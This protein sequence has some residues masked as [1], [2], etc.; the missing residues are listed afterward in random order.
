MV[1]TVTV[2][3][4]NAFSIVFLVVSSI[5]VGFRR[6]FYRFFDWMIPYIHPKKY[7][8]QIVCPI[9]ITKKMRRV[10]LKIR[11]GRDVIIKKNISK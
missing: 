4:R 5:Q 8:G 11:N 6:F 10:S 2:T 1:R 3:S 9:T 7:F